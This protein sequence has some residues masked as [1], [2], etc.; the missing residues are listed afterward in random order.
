M[1]ERNKLNYF[2]LEAL[3]VQLSGKKILYS[4]LYS[5][6]SLQN[7]I[8]FAQKIDPASATAL[9]MTTDHNTAKKLWT[10]ETSAVI[11]TTLICTHF[12]SSGTALKPCTV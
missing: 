7:F 1:L 9:P 2:Q 8:E 10:V 11:S 5:I 3:Q 4:I 12:R 6:L